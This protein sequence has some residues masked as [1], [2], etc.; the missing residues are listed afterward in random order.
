[1]I[2]SRTPFRVSLFG[3]GTDYPVWYRENGG[4]VISVS[5]NKYSFITARYLPPFF[6]YKNRIRYYLQEETKCIN[7]IK[8]PSVRECCKFLKIKDI[9]VVHNA[10][11]PARSGMGSSSTFT[12]GLLN[13][14]Y[15]LKHYMPTKKELALNAIDIEQNLIGEHVGSQDQVA[16][17]FGGLNRINF[18][19]SDNIDV[20]PIIISQKRK[21]KLQNNL[22]LFF[23]GFARNAS[24]IAKVQIENTNKK[25][26]ELN[27]IS[28]ITTEAFDIFNDSDKSID[29]LG[30]LLNKQ[31]MVKKQITDII[32]NKDIDYIYNEGIKSGA[33]G[34]KLLGA[35]GGG[36]IL[37]YVNENNQERVKRALSDYLYVPFKFDYTGSKIIYYK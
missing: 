1:M 8:H 24:D 30:D 14:L 34:G 37:F 15:G 17:A 27:K 13:A 33:L 31:W 29:E 32:S 36:F 25:Y 18:T 11:L 9:E 4:S 26:D 20:E 6:E 5:I 23:T 3:G 12:V 21:T 16:A 19:K 22:L 7:D 35:G 28:E 10:D 2:I